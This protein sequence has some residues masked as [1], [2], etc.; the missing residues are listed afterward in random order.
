MTYKLLSSIKGTGMFSH[1][2]IFAECKKKTDLP[3][4]VKL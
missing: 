1:S 4:D 2:L 3:D